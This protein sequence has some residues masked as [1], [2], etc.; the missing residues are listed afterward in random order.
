[1]SRVIRISESTYRRLE[2]LAVGFDTPGNVIERLIDFFNGQGGGVPTHRPDKAQVPAEEYLPLDPDHPEDLTHTKILEARFG[3]TRVKTW[4]QLVVTAHKYAFEH[5]GSFEALRQMTQSKI[6]LGSLDEGGYRYFPEIGISIQR[7]NA[8]N[9]WRNAL[10]I[11][12]RLKV[13]GI[14]VV[15]EWRRNK[16]AAHPGRK[17]RLKWT[18]Q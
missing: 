8:N 15:V 5:L 4:M 10:H 1:M 3:D 12:R 7:E 2:S 6:I 17:G 18:R 11:A 13:A 16:T 9:S 14:E